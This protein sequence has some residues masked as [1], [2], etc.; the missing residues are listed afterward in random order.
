M[1][2]RWICSVLVVTVVC[3]NHL[4]ATQSA[5]FSRHVVVVN[6]DGLAAY[7]VDDTRVPLSTIRQ[8]AREGCLVK[9]GMTVSDPFS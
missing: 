7:L 4:S 2:Q 3:L 9:G 6:I 1:Y 8:L 5:E